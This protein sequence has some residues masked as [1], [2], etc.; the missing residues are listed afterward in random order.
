M[1]NAMVTKVTK[2]VSDLK[3]KLTSAKDSKTEVKKLI[4]V[5]W[6]GLEELPCDL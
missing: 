5:P 2:D 6:F 1:T 3:V 4:M